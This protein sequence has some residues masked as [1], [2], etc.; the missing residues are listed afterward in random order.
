M[1]QYINQ[2]S[3]FSVASSPLPHRTLLLGTDQEEEENR[4][5]S[6]RRKREGSDDGNDSDGE[7]R[8]RIA[9]GLENGE[10]PPSDAAGP[11]AAVGGAAG[12]V[13]MPDAA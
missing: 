9:G 4:R 10:V 6:S 12:D 13:D 11:R 7:A 1:N 8:A 3:A 2:F 5:R